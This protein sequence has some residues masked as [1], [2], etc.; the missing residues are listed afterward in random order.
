MSNSVRPHQTPLSMEF[1]RQEYWSGVPCPPPGDLPN[2]GIEVR[3]PA[4]HVDS[5]PSEPP[6]KP[7]RAC[8]L[9]TR[10]LQSPKWQT[11]IFTTIETRMASLIWIS[12]LI[13][14]NDLTLSSFCLLFVFV[15][16]LSSLI[17]Q[18][19]NSILYYYL[20]FSIS[21]TLGD[22]VLYWYHLCLA[23]PGINWYSR[24]SYE[25]IMSWSFS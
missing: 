10:E 1:S 3:S 21:L 7:Q 23:M 12:S 9:P 5:L 20:C 25:L 6:G 18:L 22:P 19:L 11:G 15:M 4:L 2:P 16:S 17:S 24:N 13:I 8:C 14:H